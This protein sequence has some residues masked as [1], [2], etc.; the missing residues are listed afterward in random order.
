MF[1]VSTFT[2][3]PTLDC[4]RVADGKQQYTEL[5]GDESHHYFDKSDSPRP[6]MQ[7]ASFLISLKINVGMDARKKHRQAGGKRKGAF[8]LMFPA[9]QK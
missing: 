6:R 2:N 7:R 4:P 9:P 3:T 8:S 5:E 1:S